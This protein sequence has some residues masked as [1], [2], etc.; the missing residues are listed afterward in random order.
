MQQ[1][2]Y[3]FDQNLFAVEMPVYISPLS[4]DFLFFPNTVS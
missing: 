3:D 1:L 4:L 2:G